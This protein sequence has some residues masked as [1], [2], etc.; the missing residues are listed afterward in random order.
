MP[1]NPKPPQLVVGPDGLPLFVN[2]TDQ[3]SNGVAVPRSQDEA[4][5]PPLP[6]A[7]P[8]AAPPTQTT[9]SA[10]RRTPVATHPEGAAPPAPPTQEELKVQNATNVEQYDDP[11]TMSDTMR[12]VGGNIAQSGDAERKAMNQMVDVRAAHEARLEENAAQIREV[13]ERSIQ[14]TED[15]MEDM[16]ARTEALFAERFDP[17]QIYSSPDSAANANLH[18]GYAVGA[19]LQTIQSIVSPGSNPVNVAARIID[20]VIEADMARQREA[21]RRGEGE[22][23]QGYAAIRARQQLGVSEVEA[24]QFARAAA[25][26][27]VASQLSRVAAQY[28]GT[29]AGEAAEQAAN[30]YRLSAQGRRQQ[31]DMAA[32]ALAAQQ[33]RTAGRGRRRQDYAV[34]PPSVTHVPVEEMNPRQRGQFEAFMGD[35]SMRR[36]Y[37]QM[38]GSAHEAITMTQDILHLVTTE[39][40]VGLTNGQ[41][42]GRLLTL[43]GLL[44]GEMKEMLQLGALDD[45]V[46]NLI[47]SITGDPTERVRLSGQSEAQLRQMIRSLRSRMSTRAEMIGHSLDPSAFAA[48][49]DRS[50]ESLMMGAMESSQ[51]E[52]GGVLQA[53][54]DQRTRDAR[55]ERLE[56]EERSRQGAAARA[57]SAPSAAETRRNIVRGGRFQ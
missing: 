30:Q 35:A 48:D 10:P 21:F 43:K 36:D 53:E 45:G 52:G 16:R 51:G 55:R 27:D 37:A 14:D 54:R 4:A 20:N 47:D 15:A 44:T 49:G 39:R 29:R 38:M 31:L 28:R 9:A 33:A 42:R 17:R 50:T 40:G 1:D 22:I 19:M 25:E 11:S 23:S 41:L 26:E 57:R 8:V 7:T 32:M 46:Q 2:P 56:A 5:A 13:M 24:L 18:I 34:L 3:M 6:Q 12:A